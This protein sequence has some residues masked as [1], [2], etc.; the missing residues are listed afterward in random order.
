[1]SDD[2][3]ELFK[4][5]PQC[6][7]IMT[8][9]TKDGLRQ[10]LKT[11]SVC[12]LCQGNNRR[13]HNLDPFFNKEKEV[14][15]KHCPQCN[16]IIIYRDRKSMI[17]SLERKLICVPCSGKNKTI[18]YTPHPAYNPTTKTW[19]RYCPQCNDT[20]HYIKFRSYRNGDK[21]NAICMS[22]A[23]TEVSNRPEIRLNSSITM[24]KILS[25]AFSKKELQ[26]Y[27]LIKHL[28]FIHNDGA[29]LINI[30]GYF[31]DMVHS[32]YKLIVEFYGDRYH[33]NPK[34]KRF[35]DDSAII[36]VGR[37]IKTAKQIRDRDAKRQKILE[38]AGYQVVIV[39]E[40]NFLKEGY[41]SD[42]IK[43]IADIVNSY[44]SASLQ[45][46]VPVSYQPKSKL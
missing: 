34:D 30:C 3:R 37:E 35:A 32:D 14:W 44:S 17:R 22:C 8:F 46:L 16:Q 36:K 5:C 19:I 25:T 38:D 39:W 43:Y 41:N 1:M 9:E 20:I 31:P 23:M 10:S 26:L 33:A 2:T 21:N 18:D 29:N 40:R 24:K 27:E 15:E 13:K 11:N 12:Q 6:G 42:T 4:R 7:V 45:A 28:G